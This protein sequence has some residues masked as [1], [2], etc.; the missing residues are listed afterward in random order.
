MEK[1]VKLSKEKYLHPDHFLSK[2]EFENIYNQRLN[3][4]SSIKTELY[5]LLTDKDGSQINKYPI[6]LTYTQK[7]VE[8]LYYLRK[9]SNIIKN[10]AQDVP[11]IAQSQFKNSL[12]LGEITYTNKIEGVKTD[13]HEISTLIHQVTSV[14]SEKQEPTPKRLISSVRLYL[15]TQRKGYTQINELQDFRKIYD[16]LLKGEIP[17]DKLPTGKLFR[18]VQV[19]IGTSTKTVHTPPSTESEINTALISLINFM[20]NQDIPDII[21][22]LVTHF[23]FE[24]THPF[25]DGNGR[26]GRYLLSTYLSSKYDSFTGFSVSTAIHDRQETYYRIFK[27]A[28]QSENRAELTFFIEDFLKILLNQ[29]QKVIEVLAD[30][31]QKLTELMKKIEVIIANINFVDKVALKAILYLLAQSKLFA[32]NSQLSI[33]D[34]EIIK[35][36][37]E[38]KI[39]RSRTKLAIDF[40]EK[41]G[42][43][44]QV[45]ARPKQHILLLD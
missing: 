34:N 17:N 21:R 35:L 13:E 7:L 20:N 41:E 44:K 33:K 25:L 36:N 38:E 6:F 29:Q 43:I 31:N 4:I 26:T 2:E 22:A 19:R 23:F 32:S 42:L 3:N 40:L 27:E 24:N 1:Y 28:D 45:A 30:D 10:I 15:E 11:L 16:E 8:R 14:K 9:N 12:L 18:D 5:P 39:S 37:S